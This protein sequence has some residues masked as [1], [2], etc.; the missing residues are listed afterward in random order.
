MPVIISL[1]ANVAPLRTESGA[2]NYRLVGLEITKLDPS[3]FI[4]E[5]VVID[6]DQN[7]GET[8]VGD[9]SDFPHNII[10][11][12]CY[13]HGLPGSDLKRGIRLYCLSCAVVD[14]YISEAHVEGQEAQAILFGG[15]PL[16]IVNNYL[17]GAGENI[18][19]QDYLSRRTAT[20]LSQPT[21]NAAQLSS[22]KDLNIGDGIA[23]YDGT[24]RLYTHVTSISGTSITYEGLESVPSPQAM[25]YWGR[26][27]TDIEIAHNYLFK[28]LSLNPA[29][30]SYAGYH[31]TVKNLFE[32]KSGRRIWVHDNILENCWLDG[33]DGT[34]IL[35]TVRNQ[36]NQC[37]FCAVEDVTI[38]RNIVTNAN[39]GIGVLTTDYNYISGPTRRVAIRNNLFTHISGVFQENVIDDELIDH[40]TL[41]IGGYAISVAKGA[42][43]ANNV[44]TNNIISS[45]W[46]SGFHYNDGIIP[47]WKVIFPNWILTHNVLSRINGLSPFLFMTQYVT[48]NVE[49]NSP[50]ELMFVDWKHDNFALSPSSWARGAASD[51]GDL[52]ADIAS[53]LSRKDD[54]L[55]GVTALKQKPSFPPGSYNLPISLAATPTVARQESTVTLEAS[56]SSATPG[57]VVTFMDNGQPLGTGSVDQAGQAGFATK[58]LS[59]GTHTITASC[60]CCQGGTSVSLTIVIT[61]LPAMETAFSVD[62]LVLAG[63]TVGKTTVH[64]N[65]PSVTAIEVRVGGP[66]GALFAA[67]TN[68]G[69]AETGVWVS[70]GTVFFLQDASGSDTIDPSH[71][72]AFAVAKGTKPSLVGTLSI[73]PDPIYTYGPTGVARLTWSTSTASRVEV[74][75]GS[76][77]GPLLANGGPTGSATTDAWVSDGMTFFLQ[78][79]SNDYPLTPDYTIA[80][81]TAQ[82]IR[83]PEEGHLFINAR[84]G[85]KLHGDEVGNVATLAWSTTTANR[86]EIHVGSPDGPLF[87][88]GSS[89]GSVATGGWVSD[90]MV[91]Y[92]QDVSHQEPLT[93]EFTIARQ[94]VD[95]TAG[96]GV[97][98]QASPNP[99]LAVSG[100]K[101]GSTTLY[102]DAPGAPIVEVH[103]GTSDGPCVARAGSSGTAFISGWA[104][105]GTELYLVS[106]REDGTSQVLSKVTTHL[107]AH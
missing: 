79:R 1:G 103:A 72:L 74:H 46:A 53:L 44:F 4:Q 59:V 70:D 93:S 106:I 81:A 16:V 18:F 39:K 6:A 107:L 51:G 38:E 45:A 56:V 55:S 65:V 19:A 37:Y 14:S 82:V 2:H 49:V 13:I 54:I 87:A 27:P 20:I 25:V 48:T 62:P 42:V 100:N 73:S 96:S 31:P 57:E 40:N 71:T 98:F 67:G 90:G 21:L 26:L 10:I 80:T 36:N 105:E 52:G 84:A 86:T 104:T 68:S 47:D 94:T 3:A 17:E 43:V 66:G 41:S 89:D 15:G 85:T 32:L 61:P 88:A 28:P 76:P 99:M 77:N 35:L 63:T 33:Q 69:S 23:F 83:R 102:W 95:T 91:F 75:V 7:I 24:M 97:L 12:R 22:T 92:L 29:D 64:W 60:S 50:D 30:P 34:A 58:S 8:E 11:D 5:L 9:M 101:F 78:D